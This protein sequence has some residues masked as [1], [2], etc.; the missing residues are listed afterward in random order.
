MQLLKV[1]VWSKW[2]PR[3]LFILRDCC[4]GGSKR[5]IVGGSA[6]KV[7]DGFTSIENIETNIKLQKFRDP[8]SFSKCS[9]YNEIRVWWFTYNSP[10][11]CAFQHIHRYTYTYYTQCNCPRTYRDTIFIPKLPPRFYLPC[12]HLFSNPHSF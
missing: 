12:L 8:I 7:A 11:L 3:I 10:L 6:Y 4:L 5:E 9:E 2:D 1:G